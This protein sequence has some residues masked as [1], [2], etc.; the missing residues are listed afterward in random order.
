MPGGN[1]A[2]SGGTLNIGALSKSIGTFQITGGTV[3][4]TGTLTSSAAYDIQA[5]T[6]NAVLAGSVG[7]NKTTAGSA[8]INAPTYTGTTNVSAGT[9]TFTG[10][11]PGGNYAISGGTL[12]IGT[13]S[14]SIGTF[15][16]TGGTVSGTGTLTSNAAYDVQAGTVNAI[17]ARHVD[18]FE[19]DRL[20]DGRPHRRQ[21]LHRLDHRCIRNARI[22]IGGAERRVQP[23]RRRHPGRKAGLRLQRRHQPGGDD[24]ELADRQLRRRALGHRP[25]QE[26]DRGEHAD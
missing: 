20:R 9:L 5:G 12:N 1:Y 8:T 26:F 13:L 15:Q 2:I 25:V 4:G 3:S 18:R 16:I 11:L 22:G 23:R 17:L 6:V 24:P 7:L 10:G 14:K 21:H 19:Q